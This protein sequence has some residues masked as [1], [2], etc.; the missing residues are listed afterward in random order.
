MITRTLKLKYRNRDNTVFETVA[1]FNGKDP[2]DLALIIKDHVM[3][4]GVIGYEILTDK[5]DLRS[6]PDPSELEFEDLEDF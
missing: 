1:M 6:H 5:A 4:Y 2:Q 3:K